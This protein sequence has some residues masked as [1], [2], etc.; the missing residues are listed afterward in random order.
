MSRLVGEL[1]RNGYNK[2]E[3]WREYSNS[4]KHAISIQEKVAEI[5]GGSILDKKLIRRIKDYSESK[6]GSPGYWPWLALYSEIRGEFI[7]GWIPDDYYRNE[8]ILNLNPPQLSYLSTIKSF[9]HRLFD[10]FSLVPLAVRISDQFYDH[11]HKKIS[12]TTLSEILDYF[13][14]EIVIKSDSA[15]TGQDITFTNSR[16]LDFSIFKSHRNYVIQPAVKQ[17]SIL[18]EIH[19]S[20]LNTLRIVTVIEKGQGVRPIL[21][22]LRFG[23]GGVR[24]DKLM[25][26]GGFVEIN[27]DGSLGKYGYD[28]YGLQVSEYH[29]DTGCKFN[30]IKLPDFDKII[31]NCVNA[32]QKFPYMKMIAWDVAIEKGGNSQLIEWNSVSPGMWRYEASIGPLWDWK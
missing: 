2:F 23:T 12:N 30:E 25:D 3:S 10:G 9:D 22:V 14:S 8:M 32:H 27:K 15:A 4:R 18:S 31:G 16:D 19:Q 24:T 7:E 20:S 17:H 1:I 5:K 13:N 21:S 6:F 11:Q 29:P 28:E 26:G